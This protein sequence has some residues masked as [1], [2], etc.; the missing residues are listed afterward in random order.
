MADLVFHIGYPKTGT[1]TLQASF[2]PCHREIDYQGKLIPSHRYLDADLFEYIS[3]L[4]TTPLLEWSMLES[5]RSKIEYIVAESKKKLVLFSSENFLH[6]ETSDIGLVAERLIS[7]FPQAR[8][9]ITIREQADILYSFYR[10]H[11]VFGQYLF[12]MKELED[13]LYLPIPLDDWLRYQFLTPHKNILGTL[14]YG[15][16]INQ[17]LELFGQRN[18]LVSVFE[19]LQN[20]PEKFYCKICD[21][22]GIQ[23]DWNLI[24]NIELH[25]PSLD[26]VRFE[27]IK[28]KIFAQNRLMTSSEE[29]NFEIDRSIP[30]PW[31]SKIH[32]RFRIGNRIVAELTKLNLNDYGY[33]L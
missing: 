15:A 3:L 11:G 29:I 17:Y 5:I 13:P 2:F 6:P 7:A 26:A 32:D 25:N 22:L 31:L 16:V 1:T 20:Y 19:Q 24:N 33:A 18:V 14:N 30:E 27:K 4:Q 23:R 12:T 21:F 8:I 9:M 28:G 10:N